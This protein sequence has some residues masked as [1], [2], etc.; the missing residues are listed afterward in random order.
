MLQTYQ[1][2][3][4]AVDGSPEAELAFEKAIHV[5]L[6]NQAKLIITHVID[7]RSLHTYSAFDTNI[8]VNLEKEARAQLA[9]YEDRARQA[10][11]K[12]IKQVLELG[13]PRPLLAKEIPDREQVDLILLGATGLNSFERLLIGSSSEY[14]MRNARVDLLIVRDPNKV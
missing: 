6:R 5:A 9:A 1:T 12:H 3:M 13:D 4:V 8:Y 10:G 14:I 11:L 7:N 2:I